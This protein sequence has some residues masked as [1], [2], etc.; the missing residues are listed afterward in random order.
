MEFIPQAPVSLELLQPLSY[1]PGPHHCYRGSRWGY[2]IL[3]PTDIEPGAILIHADGDQLPGYREGYE[4]WMQAFSSIMP[5][6]TG[7]ILSQLGFG[8]GF[9]R[10][11]KEGEHRQGYLHYASAEQVV[12]KLEP[13]ES[14]FAALD[15]PKYR[16]SH[17]N[18]FNMYDSVRALKD[19]A[20]L[21]SDSHAIAGYDAG[22]S[23]SLDLFEQ[24]SYEG[25]DM[26]RH[27]LPWFGLPPV[28][29]REIKAS[30]AELCEGF[31]FDEPEHPAQS[32]RRQQIYDFVAAID[33][34]MLVDRLSWLV[35]S[36]NKRDIRNLGNDLKQKILPRSFHLSV[37]E[38]ETVIYENILQPYALKQALGIELMPELAHA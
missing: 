9:D 14:N 6:Q 11:P 26:I 15:L 30:A 25:H 10:D 18:R 33:S 36:E 7:Q 2:A 32:V 20:V 23:S 5:T 24:E 22:S 1:A 29:F 12:R 37:D 19:G 28:I 17:S 21:L 13:Y 27:F 34:T 31:D 3:P 16:L 4:K 35:E 38:I 8:V